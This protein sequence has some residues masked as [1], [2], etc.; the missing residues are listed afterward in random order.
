MALRMH[1]LYRKFPPHDSAL[2]QT[3]RVSPNATAAEIGRQYRRISREFH[4]DKI[5]L[6]RERMERRDKNKKMG[7][8]GVTSKQ[9]NVDKD[10]DTE[11]RE[12]CEKELA[13]VREAYEILKEDTTRLLYHKYGLLDASHAAA[14]LTGNNIPMDS[15]EARNAHKRL[16]QLMGYPSHSHPNA[17]RNDDF[18]PLGSH[19]ERHPPHA[20]HDKTSYIAA[21]LLETIRPLVEGT[22][23]ANHYAHYLAQEYD[24]LKVLPLGAPILRCIG[25]AYRL[26]GQGVLDQKSQL[27]HHRHA[28]RV[29]LRSAKHFMEA[30]TAGGRYVFQESA[31]NVRKRHREEE[32]RR[33]KK[34]REKEKE[35][36]KITQARKDGEFQNVSALWIGFARVYTRMLFIVMYSFS[37]NCLFHVFILFLSLFLHV[38]LIGHSSFHRCVVQR[39]FIL[40]RIERRRRLGGW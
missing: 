37:C 28:V 11:F 19:G 8:K 13:K 40:W 24:R 35:K 23:D 7:E 38:N 2:Y 20:S 39:L 36:Q 12:Q 21:N 25:R 27:R 1:G 6:L 26:S 18:N 34:R 9:A 33:K 15:Q 31:A 17:G 16:L 4:P 32:D 30:A 22:V 3:L 10:E 5:V 29:Q 14:L